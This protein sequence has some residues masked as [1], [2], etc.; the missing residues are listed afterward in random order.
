LAKVEDGGQPPPV[1]GG[2]LVGGE[3]VGAL[4]TRLSCHCWLLPPQSSYWTTLPPSAVEAFWTST[5]LP[6]LRLMSRT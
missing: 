1:V 3:D 4:P 5:A 2:A 6:L